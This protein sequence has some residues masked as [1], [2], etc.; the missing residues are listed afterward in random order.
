M[1]VT[2]QAS[3]DAAVRYLVISNLVTMRLYVI[4]AISGWVGAILT[5]KIGHRGISIWCF[6]IVFTSLP[7]AAAAI[8]TG[9]KGVLPF[10]AAAMLWGHY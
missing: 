3:M 2:G 5:P 8:Y 9:H 1:A 6:G 7:A 10:V 4:A